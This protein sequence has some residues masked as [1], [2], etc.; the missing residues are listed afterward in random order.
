MD[1]R[2]LMDSHPVPAATREVIADIVAAVQ[3]GD[4]ARIGVLLARLAPVADITA[5]LLLRHRLNHDLGGPP[6]PG[7]EVSGCSGGG[8]PD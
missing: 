8:S 4:D 6:Q 1:I 5:L 2:P 7:P 3:A